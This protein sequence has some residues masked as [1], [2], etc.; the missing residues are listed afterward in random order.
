MFQMYC[1]PSIKYMWALGSIHAGRLL[2]EQ[3]IYATNLVF[4]VFKWA[5]LGPPFAFLQLSPGLL[6]CLSLV[7]V[8]M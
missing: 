5:K 7:D 3:A 8:V 2:S 4:F 1:A 6:F